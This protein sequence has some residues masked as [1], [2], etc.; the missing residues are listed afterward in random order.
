MTPGTLRAARYRA[1]SANLLKLGATFRLGT[2]FAPMQYLNEKEAT[3]MES[4]KNVILVSVQYAHLAV[5]TLKVAGF[6]H[7]G[8]G[9][10]VRI[11]EN[12]GLPFALVPCLHQCNIYM[13]R[14]LREWR[15]QKCNPSFGARSPPRSTDLQSTRFQ[16]ARYR[17]DSANL[18]KLGAIFRLGTVFAPKQ[19]L[20]EKEAR[21]MYSPEM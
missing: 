16:A 15:V 9:P 8:I 21:E 3:G 1:N 10:T 2:V 19:Y 7:R 13:K 12:S 6:R 14:K 4:P 20:Y 18:R 17:A 11:C 5:R